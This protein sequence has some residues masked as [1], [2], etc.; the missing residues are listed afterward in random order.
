[1]VLATVL[2]KTGGRLIEIVRPGRAL[3][4]GTCAFVLRIVG[5]CDENLEVL[6]LC[7][8]L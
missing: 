3:S 1:M 8:N 7:P 6:A 5:S 2:V 4:T